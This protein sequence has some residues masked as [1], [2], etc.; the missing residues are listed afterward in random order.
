MEQLLNK[1]QNQELETR[2]ILQNYKYS[3]R[4]PLHSDQAYFCP[5]APS[6]RLC[7]PKFHLPAKPVPG[8]PMSHSVFS[9][10]THRIHSCTI[11]WRLKAQWEPHDRER[12]KEWIIPC[13]GC[14]TR[15]FV[16]GSECSLLHLGCGLSQRLQNARSKLPLRS[17]LIQHNKYKH[18]F[19]KQKIN[20]SNAHT[21]IMSIYPFN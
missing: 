10:P 1:Y 14:L 17:L 5:R 4:W 2:N 12:D 6:N 11:V 9:K 13:S 15:P 20:N 19:K 7:Y 16:R 21:W 8:V 3:H 18:F